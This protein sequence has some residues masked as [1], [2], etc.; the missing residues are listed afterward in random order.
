MSGGARDCPYIQYRYVGV[1]GVGDRDKKKTTE[2]D[3]VGFSVSFVLGNRKTDFNKSVFGRETEKKR[4]K[5]STF[6]FRFT[7]L[8]LAYISTGAG[9][10]NR[11]T[12]S[13]RAKNRYIQTN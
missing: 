1:I 3:R 6:G 10:Q 13:H 8:P 12:C 11:Y 2:K 4:P 5:K 9:A 7:T